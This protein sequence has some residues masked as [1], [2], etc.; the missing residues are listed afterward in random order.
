LVSDELIGF[1]TT[2]ILYL[3]PMFTLIAVVVYGVIGTKSA[4]TTHISW[5]SIEKVNPVL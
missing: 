3:W 4:L 2:T 5:L 1:A